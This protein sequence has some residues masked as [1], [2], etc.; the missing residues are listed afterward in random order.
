MLTKRLCLLGVGSALF[1][2]CMTLSGYYQLTAY[3]ASGDVVMGNRKNIAEGSG[4]YTVRNALC[5]I[6]S[7]AVV[8]IRD[9]KTGEELKS[10]SPYQCR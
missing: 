10:E 2:G 4:I 1:A 9:N 5:G 6:P 7:V 3:N 8:V